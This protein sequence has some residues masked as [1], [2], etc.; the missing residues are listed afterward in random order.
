MTA[1]VDPN[2]RIEVSVMVRPRRPLE[3]IEATLS[4]RQPAAEPYLSREEFAAEYGA[5]P[6]DLAKVEEFA[7]RRG[8]DVVE[9]S[10]ARRT[11]RLGGRAADIS[12]AFGVTFRRRRL[13]DGTAHRAYDGE[14]A[15]PPELEGVVQSVFGLDNRPVARR[16]C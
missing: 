2:E 13:P 4:Q 6:A 8:L 10:P 7:R 15:L 11:V 12:A 1:E 9:S 3:E 16:D 5:D 14:V